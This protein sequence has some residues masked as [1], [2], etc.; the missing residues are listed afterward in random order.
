MYFYKKTTMR[1]ALIWGVF[2]LCTHVAYG[3]FGLTSQARHTFPG[4]EI[5]VKAGV[6]IQRTSGST[7]WASPFT[8]GPM[9]GAYTSFT[10]GNLGWRAELLGKMGWV[11][12]KKTGE[13]VKCIYF[14]VPLLAEYR[15]LDVITV[16]GGVVYTRLISSR[17]MTGGSKLNM[18][19][20]ENDVSLALGA[21]VR[22]GRRLA[23]NARYLNGFLNLN[24]V[25]NGEKWK[26]SCLQ[27]T[28]GYRFFE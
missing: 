28:L 26:N 15:V 3:Q 23:V 11:Q 7:I 5:G 19:F 16:H 12:F 6:N 9:A 2:S 27:L 21:E 10:R 22:V 4:I 1:A 8:T 20:N 14:D 18:M 24:S 17:G 13:D 25:E